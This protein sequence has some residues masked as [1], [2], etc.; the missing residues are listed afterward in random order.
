M[1]TIDSGT[2]CQ[3]L[4]NYGVKEDRYGK[5]V[6]LL[7]GAHRRTPEGKETGRMDSILVRF[8]A[9]LDV[10]SEEA[11]NYLQAHALQEGDFLK[12]GGNLHT[13]SDQHGNF[14]ASVSG[15][16]IDSAYRDS[17]RKRVEEWRERQKEKEEVAV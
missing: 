8:R 15:K 12:F 13:S 5:V 16:Y 17:A 2:E 4:K 7:V 14:Y 11:E 9:S 6:T 10:T 1:F 3:V